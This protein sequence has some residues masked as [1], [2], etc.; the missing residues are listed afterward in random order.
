MNKNKVILSIETSCDDTSIAI[1]E[2]NL[3]KANV[4]MSS[5]LEQRKYGGI[6]P[7]VASRSH[8]DLIDIVYKKALV[9]A[10]VR[11]DDLTHI[12]YTAEPG[13]VGSLHVGKVFAKQLASLLNIPC[14]PLNHMVGHVFSYFIDHN[15]KPT[16][17]FI[18]LIVS[19]GHTFIALFKSIQNYT[20]LNS[21]NDDAAGEALD[22]IGRTLG[23]E[24]PGGISIDKAYDDQK[25]FLSFIKHS[26]PKN[27]FS[28]SGI[29]TATL[30]FINSRKMKDEDYDVCEIGSSVLKWV[31][32][33][34]ILKLKFYI[35][36]YNIKY[37]LLGGGVSANSLLRKMMKE[38]FQENIV[39]IPSLKYT[40]DNAA[41]IGIYSYYLLESKEQNE[42]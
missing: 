13:L 1:F 4:T 2:N 9:E 30:N 29:K 31:C 40:G 41:M 7:E 26:P 34:L 27:P 12:A 5:L 15:E 21:C 3:L 6:V 11:C 20:I 18:T 23:L 17:P 16:F 33:D 36:Q 14:L 8:C 24:Y 28:F 37:I 42:Q 39:L 10:N 32:D 22:K 25:S 19:G 38:N 35:S